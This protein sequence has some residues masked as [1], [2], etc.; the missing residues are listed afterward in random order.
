LTDAPG[1]P[2]TSTLRVGLALGGI[3]LAAVVIFGLGVMEGS[4][5]AGRAPADA[6][7]PSALPTETL[8]TLSPAATAAAPIPPDKLTFYD[9]LSG[10]APAAPVALPAG[11]APAQGQTPAA[12]DTP[13]RQPEAQ[14]PPP[15]AG[16]VPRKTAAPAAAQ[17]A[18]KTAV[19]SKADPAARIRKL[20]GKGRFTVQMAAVNE[21]A[22]AAETAAL[23]KRN[24]F[25][26]VT[27]MA[28][29]KGKI[30][31]RIRV[32]SFPSKQAA[33]Q[34]AAIFRSAYGLNAIPVED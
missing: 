20:T 22:A 31:Y 24:G 21:R 34:A 19:P 11:Q 23:I 27:V 7:P 13:A 9:R 10:V 12:Q 18:A 25:E 8:N 26:A 15:A 30:W 4:R 1:G 6:D 32:G 29:V 17:T 14:A 28:S 3:V 33:N 2:G 16:G 5:V